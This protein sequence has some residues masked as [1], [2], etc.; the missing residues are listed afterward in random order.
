MISLN[1][2]NYPSQPQSLEAAQNRE[3]ISNLYKTGEIE[4]SCKKF[5]AAG[6]TGAELQKSELTRQANL[7]QAQPNW[8]LKMVNI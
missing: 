4:N 1:H 8:E 6:L 5:T 2:K 3:R 7:G